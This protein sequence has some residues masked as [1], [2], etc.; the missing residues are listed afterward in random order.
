VSVGGVGSVGGKRV[1]SFLPHP[2]P[3]DLWVM[4]SRILGG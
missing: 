3:L 2:S 1:N 4:D